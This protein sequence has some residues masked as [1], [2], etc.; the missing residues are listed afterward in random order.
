[1]LTLALSTKVSPHVAVTAVTLTWVAAIVLAERLTTHPYAAFGLDTQ[2][3]LTAIGAASIVLL[4]VRRG[5]LETRS[6]A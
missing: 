2:L 3:I 4:I 1:V 5:A 6:P